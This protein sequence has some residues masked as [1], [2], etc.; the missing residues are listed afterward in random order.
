MKCVAVALALMA[1]TDSTQHADTRSAIISGSDAPDDR[2]VVALVRRSVR[3]QPESVTTVE[4]TATVVGRR[5][6]LTAAH[7][8]GGGP[9]NGFEVVFA[10]VVAD[11]VT[12]I[13]IVGGRAHPELDEVT[14]A[15]DIAVLILGGDA[16]ADVVPLPVELA[17]LPD[18]TGTDVRLV[19]YGVTAPAS[20]DVGTRRSGI[21][22]VTEVSTDELRMAPNP[23]MSCRGDSGGPVLAPLAGERVVA[24][25][26]WGDPG[27]AQFGVAVRVD[28]HAAFV[29]SILD[30]SVAP[31]ARRAFDAG[32][33]FCR[34]SCSQDADCADE[35]VCFGGR[36]LYRGLPAGELG[37]RCDRDGACQCVALPDGTCREFVP[38]VGEDET[39]RAPEPG[40]GC[41][42]P[43]GGGTTAL[44]V[45]GLMAW[46][47]RARRSDRAARR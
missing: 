11:G 32:E 47:G 1:C 20:V 21:A 10:A 5:A 23:A 18:L 24:V 19:G 45:L 43:S 17:A 44:V 22:Q 12:R 33:H 37:A 46:V 3:C 42:A 27:C 15:N 8:L 36:C 39:C 26:A 9:P 7:C 4:C 30:E 40:C 2:A 41:R 35:T 6:V 16:P 34:A 28:R 14:H 13:P 25:T 38:C 31:P 29:R